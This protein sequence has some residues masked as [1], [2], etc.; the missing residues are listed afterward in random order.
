MSKSKWLW[1]IA[2]TIIMFSL[3]VLTAWAMGW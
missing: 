1:P 2:R 3:G